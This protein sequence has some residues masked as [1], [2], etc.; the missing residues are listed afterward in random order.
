MAKPKLKHNLEKRKTQRMN[1]P[2]LAIYIIFNSI[3]HSIMHKQQQE[4]EN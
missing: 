2:N 1:E 4:E 3:T